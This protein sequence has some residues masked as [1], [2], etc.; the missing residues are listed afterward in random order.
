MNHVITDSEETSA[1][2]SVYKGHPHIGQVKL[3]VHDTKIFIAF[4]ATYI[5][6][7]KNRELKIVENHK[8]CS[9]LVKK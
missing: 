5:F 9:H 1:T 2:H 4:F 7:T 3:S 8:K 6:V